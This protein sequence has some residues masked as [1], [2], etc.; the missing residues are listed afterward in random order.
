MQQN[1]FYTARGYQIIENKEHKL[2]ASLEDYIEMIYRLTSKYGYTRVGKL[3]EML[4]VKPSSVSKML[5]KLAELSIVDYEKYGIITLTKLGKDYG[6]YFIWRHNVI[7]NFF[8]ILLPNDKN[9]AFEEAEL[10]EHMLSR[11][12]VEGIEN[13]IKKIK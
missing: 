10:V 5:I 3:A 7:N 8:S 2:T 11:E 4:N 1:K 6:E 12:T 13:I 9:K